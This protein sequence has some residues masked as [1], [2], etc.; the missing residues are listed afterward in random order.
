[1]RTERA[2]TNAAVSGR[3][4]EATRPKIDVR[5]RYFSHARREDPGPNV[6]TFGL[7]SIRPVPCWAEAASP[8]GSDAVCGGSRRA[9]LPKVGE[10]DSLSP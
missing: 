9:R 7:W 2:C 1:M 6:G 5:A 8:G 4:S 10:R 3:D